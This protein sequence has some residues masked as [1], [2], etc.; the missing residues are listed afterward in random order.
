MYS[1]RECGTILS[2]GSMIHKEFW[3]KKEI[4][5]PKE[6]DKG[7]KWMSLRLWALEM[8]FSYEVFLI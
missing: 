6:T 2:P 3:R 8:S 7:T 5:G 1:P 4:K